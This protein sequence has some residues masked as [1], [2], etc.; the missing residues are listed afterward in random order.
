MFPVAKLTPADSNA[1][2]VQAMKPKSDPLNLVGEND[3]AMASKQGYDELS[4]E[5]IIPTSNGTTFYGEINKAIA[6]YQTR[7]KGKIR[8]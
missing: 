6:N 8:L 7:E 5:A 4:P 2:A 1:L 3:V